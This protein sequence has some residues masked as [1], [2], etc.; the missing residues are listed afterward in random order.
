VTVEA[1]GDTVLERVLAT[2]RLR[3]DVMALH[4]YAR[5]FVAQA[6]ATATCQ[7]RLHLYVWGKH[8]SLPT[9]KVNHAGIAG[10]PFLRMTR[11]AEAE[12]RCPESQARSPR[13]AV[14]TGWAFSRWVQ[15]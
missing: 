12:S 11:R 9:S 2:F 15:G 7:H 4:P 1:Q 6:T 13:C 3:D 14:A 8:F 5:E 10:E